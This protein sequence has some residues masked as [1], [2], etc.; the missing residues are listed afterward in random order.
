M[1]TF[2]YYESNPLTKESYAA[3]AL[4]R[5]ILREDR[6]MRKSQPKANK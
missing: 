5:L 3:Q 6:V 1:T 4:C 2:E